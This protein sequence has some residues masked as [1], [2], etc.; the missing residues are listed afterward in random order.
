MPI[1]AITIAIAAAMKPKTPEA[2]NLSKMKAMM[3]ELKMTEG[4]LQ[5]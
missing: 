2:P 3:K 5:E 1:V 4:R